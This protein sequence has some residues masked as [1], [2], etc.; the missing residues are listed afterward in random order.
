MRMKEARGVMQHVTDADF[1]VVN[2]DFA[3]A[4]DEMRAIIQARSL[5]VEAQRAR[6]RPLLASLT[7]D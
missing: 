3:T 1:L 7:E 5:R 2:E 4:L 6:L